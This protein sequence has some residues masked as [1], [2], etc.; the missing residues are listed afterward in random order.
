MKNEEP[1]KV[2]DVM[3]SDVRVCHAHDTLEQAAQ[4][5]WEHDCGCLPVVDQDG[6]VLAMVTD[7]DICMAAYTRGRSLREIRVTD[8]MSRDLAC[9][10][11]QDGLAEAAR[12]MGERGVRRLPVTD[13]GGRIQGILSMND[14]ACACCGTD[15]GGATGD[16]VSTPMLQALIGVSRH[17]CGDQEAPKYA[18]TKKRPAR[19]ESVP[20]V[21]GARGSI[22]QQPEG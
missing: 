11:P 22:H 3:T 19:K 9:C 14:M 15:L 8:A 20:G 10:Q 5:L 12:R 16:P 4:M 21:G 1:T 13:E 2:Q 6:V 18:A 17:R 7:R